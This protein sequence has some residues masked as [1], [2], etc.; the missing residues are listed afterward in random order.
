M[1]DVFLPPHAAS[2]AVAAAPRD[3]DGPRAC[4]LI[5]AVG[6]LAQNAFRA[7]SAPARAAGSSR[8]F[9]DQADVGP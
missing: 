1:S 5:A 8:C 9:F 7:C 6:S 3:P 2:P 4:A